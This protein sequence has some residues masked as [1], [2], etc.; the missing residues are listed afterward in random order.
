MKKQIGYLMLSFAFTCFSET[1][2]ARQAR[3]E[4]LH[5]AGKQDILGRGISPNKSNLIEQSEARKIAKYHLQRVISNKPSINRDIRYHFDKKY[6]PF[7]SQ[8]SF[9][10][11]EVDQLKLKKNKFCFDGM[12]PEHNRMLG[13]MSAHGT[14]LSRIKTLQIKNPTNKQIMYILRACL[15]PSCAF[16]SIACDM[17]N[18]IAMIMDGNGV[19]YIKDIQNIRPFN[20]EDV[21]IDFAAEIICLFC[22][23]NEQKHTRKLK[24]DRGR[25]YITV[26][27]DE[28]LN[29][30]FDVEYI[31][32][33]A[34]LCIQYGG[35]K[36]WFTPMSFDESENNS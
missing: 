18:S 24:Y 29:G 27:T 1:Y 25:L 22:R 6:M 26:P 21:C 31:L 9:N 19:T 30:I 12:L 10:E 16:E 32:Q 36:P 15:N 5:K 7:L 35:C 2:G 23:S 14:C 8:L 3:N 34:E 13:I 33:C 20:D 11:A 17:G 4:E 28:D